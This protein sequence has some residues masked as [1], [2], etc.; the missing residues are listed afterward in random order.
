MPTWGA[1]ARMAGGA[2]RWGRRTLLRRSALV[3][4]GAALGPAATV[5]STWVADRRLPLAG[6]P[7]SATL[8][9]RRQDV[10]GGGVE[11][12][13]GSGSALRWWR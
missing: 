10:G 5:E 9:N 2:S 11:V 6:G 12:V 4:G 3:L 7:A 8:G 13:W 1:G